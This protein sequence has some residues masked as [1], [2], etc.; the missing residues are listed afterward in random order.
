M[1]VVIKRA[2]RKGKKYEAL[3]DGKTVAFGAA[4]YEDF[5]T[6]KNSKRKEA[7]IARHRITEDWT[8]SGVE[9]AGFYAKHI[10]WNKPSV[11]ASV[12][13]LN[14]RFSDIDFVLR[15]NPLK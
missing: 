7:Y 6:H 3:V 2:G 14:A 11:A 13:D 10:L 9:S 8:R 1:K 15:K 12:R 4:G 5:T